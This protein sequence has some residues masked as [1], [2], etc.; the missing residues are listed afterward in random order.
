ML[1]A[2]AAAVAIAVYGLAGILC[3]TSLNAT[4][5]LLVQLYN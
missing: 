1:L 2:S 3:V 5:K 4:F